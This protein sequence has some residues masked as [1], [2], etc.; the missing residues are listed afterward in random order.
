GNDTGTHIRELQQGFL[1]K[2]RHDYSKPPFPR[3][4]GASRDKTNNVQSWPQR[5]KPCFCTESDVIV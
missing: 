1:Q 4:T 2:K 5:I 3:P